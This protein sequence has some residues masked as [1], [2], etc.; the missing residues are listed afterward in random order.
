MGFEQEATEVKRTILILHTTLI[1]LVTL[2]SPAYAQDLFGLPTNYTAGDNPV[3]VFSEDLDGDGDND[4][5]VA[6]E[7][8]SNV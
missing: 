2:N 5:A 4:L 6:N 3:S 8:S 1:L 7:V